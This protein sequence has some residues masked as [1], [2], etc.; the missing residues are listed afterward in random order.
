MY[1]RAGI[2]TLPYE[3]AIIENAS[4]RVDFCGICVVDLRFI[5]GDI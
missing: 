3:C 4:I 5:Y 2:A 1:L